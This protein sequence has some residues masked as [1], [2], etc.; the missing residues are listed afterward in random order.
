MDP[1]ES[2]PEYQ[3]AVAVLE[4]ELQDGDITQKGFEKKKAQLYQELIFRLT[5]PSRPRPH[6]GSPV[7]VNYI[8]S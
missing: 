7:C 8:F 5:S 2:L 3:E 6:V 1:V 4:R